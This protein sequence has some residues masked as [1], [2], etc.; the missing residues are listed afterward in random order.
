MKTPKLLLCLMMCAVALT[1]CGD[2]KKS[3]G[4]SATSCNAQCDAQEAVR[5]MG[6]EPFV[7]LASCKQLCTQL[8]ASSE[9]CA[10]QFD[11]YYE[12]LTADGFMCAGTLVTSKT[13]ACDDEQSALSD[14]NSGGGTGAGSGAGSGGGGAG[15]GSGASCEGASASGVCPQVTC[16]CPGGNQMI[17]GFDNS[18]GHCKCATVG[19]CQDFCF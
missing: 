8:A 11:A 13:N 15:T 19:T 1:A 2:K 16:P 5:S 7:D 9:G 18:S 10:T 3:A 12:C 4:A 17:S 14:C 6:C